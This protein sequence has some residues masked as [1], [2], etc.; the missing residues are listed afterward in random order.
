MAWL[1]E[2]G[3]EFGDVVAKSDNEPALTSF[4]R[5]VAQ[6]ARDEGMIA[7]D[8]REQSSGQWKRVIQWVQGMIKTIRSS[9]EKRW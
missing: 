5:V 6:F 4:D 8:C 3:L 9:L 7:D 1:R 2:I